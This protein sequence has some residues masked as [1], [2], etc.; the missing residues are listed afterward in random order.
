MK[1][2]DF[3]ILSVDSDYISKKNSNAFLEVTECS[4]LGYFSTQIFSLTGHMTKV[5]LFPKTKK[6][7]TCSQ[8]F[9]K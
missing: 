2:D 9:K 4:N 8:N 3:L 5:I 7:T 6:S 1:S